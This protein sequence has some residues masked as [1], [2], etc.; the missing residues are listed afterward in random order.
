MVFRGMSACVP[1]YATAFF[2]CILCV[3]SARLY[4][5][6]VQ[7]RAFIVGASAKLVQ[8]KNQ[9]FVISSDMEETVR[10]EEWAQ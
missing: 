6:S 9:R 7:S 4:I 1:C 2:L 5:H 3:L 10:T 8:R